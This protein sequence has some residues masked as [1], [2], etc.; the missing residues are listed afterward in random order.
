MILLL[1]WPHFNSPSRPQEKFSAVVVH[2]FQACLHCWLTY[3]SRVCPRPH[4]PLLRLQQNK[5]NQAVTVYSL[6]SADMES[7]HLQLRATFRNSLRLALSPFSRATCEAFGD[8][9]YRGEDGEV[10]L[11]VVEGPHISQH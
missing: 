9:G 6:Y 3:S 2:F 10:E 1:L 7:V 11:E 5:L 4:F 8:V